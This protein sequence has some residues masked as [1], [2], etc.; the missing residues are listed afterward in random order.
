MMTPGT[1][2]T[3]AI[4]EGRDKMPSDIVSAIMRSEHCHQVSVR[5]LTSAF[6]SSPKGSPGGP[7]LLPL[8]SG[9]SASWSCI[10]ASASLEGLMLESDMLS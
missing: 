3:V 7:Y 9:E 6:V 4:T 1:S 10:L 8:R 2:P 5:Y